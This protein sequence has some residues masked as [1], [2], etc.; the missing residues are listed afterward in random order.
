[1]NIVTHNLFAEHFIA[2]AVA[3]DASKSPKVT[4]GEA[5]VL[6]SKN[7]DQECEE[8]QSKQYVRLGTAEFVAKGNYGVGA[9]ARAQAGVCG[10]TLV[11]FSLV[12]AK[13]RA[14]KREPNGGIN[15]AAVLADPPASLSPRGHYVVRAVFMRP[16]PSLQPTCYGL[17][18]PHAAEL[19][20]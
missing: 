15:L 7:L 19:K 18:P 6:M 13:L 2:Q 9:E 3:P 12:P 16:N 1:M 17:R 11:L 10:A 14:V 5:Q 4:A 20:R 8:W